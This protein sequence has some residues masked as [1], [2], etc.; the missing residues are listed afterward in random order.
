MISPYLADAKLTLTFSRFLISD[1]TNKKVTLA[2]L[3]FIMLTGVG[4]AQEY[5]D[6]FKCLDHAM[7]NNIQIKLNEISVSLADIQRRQDK[8]AFTPSVNASAGYNNAVGRTVDLTTY[9]FVTRPVQTGNMQVSL[10]QPLFQG[11]RN[12]QN[13]RK[14]KLDLEA[15]RLDNQALREEISLQVMNAYLNILNAEEQLAQSKEQLQRTQQQMDINKTLVEGGAL[16]ERMLVDMEAQLASEEYN[17]ILLEQQVELSYLALKTLLQLDHQ[18]NIKL[19][20]P[21]LPETLEVVTPDPASV[22]FRE[23]LG[24]RPDIKSG[25]LKIS[26]AEKGIKVA[27][28]AYWP[29]INFFTAGQTNVS[30]QFTER[31]ISDTIISP[32]GYVGSSGETVFTFIPQTGFRNVAFGNQFR[33]NFSFAVGVNMSIPIYNKRTFYFNAERSRLAL[34]QSELNQKNLEFTLMNNITEAHLKATTS[35]ENYKA[36][37]KNVEAATKSYQFV[38]ERARSGAISQL[39]TNLAQTNLS[40]AE[41]RLIQAKYEY[42]FNLKVLDFY[43]GRPINFD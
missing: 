3:H 5:W 15:A 41:S 43:R 12:L 27:K 33:N 42:L 32:I 8:L 14:S 25:F 18:Q 16:A 23:A 2:I 19:T 24:I 36:A 31:F 22:I 37:I 35:A 39:E 30:D 28:S 17:V 26:S 11:L 1:M 40:I 9:Q 21:Q 20:A 38:Q 6:W 7:S 4:H 29:T 10:N 13:Y 34:E